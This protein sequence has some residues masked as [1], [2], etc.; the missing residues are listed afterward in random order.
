MDTGGKRHA[1]LD[2]QLAIRLP[3]LGLVTDTSDVMWKVTV[4]LTSFMDMVQHN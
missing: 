4:M 3:Y 1:I 2:D